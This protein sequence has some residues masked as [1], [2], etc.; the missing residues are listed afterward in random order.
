MAVQ[1]NS[2]EDV[3][4]ILSALN[5]KTTLDGRTLSEVAIE[6]FGDGTIPVHGVR[7]TAK[8]LKEDITKANTSIFENQS[9]IEKLYEKI[10]IKYHLSMSKIIF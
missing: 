6:V 5:S 8:I 2:L 4:T 7:K 3:E 1:S 9:F 10:K